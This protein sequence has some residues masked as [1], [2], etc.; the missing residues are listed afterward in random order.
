MAIAVNPC[1]HS[2]LY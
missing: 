2:A 1:R